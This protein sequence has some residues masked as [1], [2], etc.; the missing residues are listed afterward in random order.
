MSRIRS[1]LEISCPIALRLP[2]SPPFVSTE[3]L[4]F[5]AESLPFSM[6]YAVA[7]NDLLPHLDNAFFHQH[8]LCLAAASA[9]DG[10]ESDYGGL[11]VSD[12]GIQ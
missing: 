11:L 1:K 3:R 4:P 9:L 10:R 12:S 5:S 2:E 6:D 7:Q 8:Q